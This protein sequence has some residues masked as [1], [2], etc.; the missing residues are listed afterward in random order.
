MR[1][2]PFSKAELGLIKKRPSKG[3]IPMRITRRVDGVLKEV[4]VKKP[5]L[6]EEEAM[7][8][9]GL[10][11]LP[12][13]PPEGKMGKLFNSVMKLSARRLQTF[14]EKEAKWV[15]KEFKRR[16]GRE[17]VDYL[18]WEVA[19]PMLYKLARKE[20]LDSMPK[21]I[22]FTEESFNSALMNRFKELS[23]KWREERQV[24][25]AKGKK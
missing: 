17:A 8:L 7:L 12:M 13:R 25:K 5:T 9:N 4:E 16:G 20:T 3:R 11:P 24:K 22:I 14:A 2:D 23:D 19:E 18:E 15:L 1:K 21:G 10:G 6:E